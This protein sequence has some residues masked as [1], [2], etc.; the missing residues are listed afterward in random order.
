M[1]RWF[2]FYKVSLMGKLSL[3]PICYFS[4][5]ELLVSLLLGRQGKNEQSIQSG[6]FLSSRDLISLPAARRVAACN[7]LQKCVSLH[8]LSQQSE[9]N[10]KTSLGPPLRILKG[11]LT[12][13]FDHRT[14]A[15]KPNLVADR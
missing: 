12:H 9:M 14:S 3:Y 8:K 10:F 13:V 11:Q 15:I 6:V 5:C 1:E 7:F 4:W 2:D